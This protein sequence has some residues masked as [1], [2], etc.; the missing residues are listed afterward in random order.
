GAHAAESAARGSEAPKRRHPF[1]SYRGRGGSMIVSDA[2]IEALLFVAGE[3]ITLDEIARVL[4]CDA[5]EAEAGVRELQLRLGETRSGLQLL[6]IAGG[7]QLSTRPEHADVI[8]RLL[9]RT[10]TRLSRA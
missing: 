6:N 4:Q 5:L 8:G 9:A 10:A 7:Y 1:V 3:P 2:A